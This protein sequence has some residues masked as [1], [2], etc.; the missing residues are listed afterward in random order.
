MELKYANSSYLNIY[1]AI[2]SA[3][4]QSTERKF[5]RRFSRLLNQYISNI[6]NL[7]N[8]NVNLS[9]ESQTKCDNMFSDPESYNLFSY[10]QL[11]TWFIY[12]F[13]SYVVIIHLLKRRE[14]VVIYCKVITNLIELT[15]AQILFTNKCRKVIQNKI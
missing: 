9:L 14:G 15:R 12:F 3:C 10:F 13:L 2:S 5:H 7:Y 8:L 4:S 6:S 1:P 11:R